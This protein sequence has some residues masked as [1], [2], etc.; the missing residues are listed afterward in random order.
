MSLVEKAAYLKGL[1]DGMELDT[2]KK[3]TRL[4]KSVIDLL[5]DMAASVEEL[6]DSTENIESEL[7][8]VAEE[9]LGI[10]HAL[11]CDCDSF[12]DEDDD[13]CG[14]GE[15]FYYQVACPTCGEE[16]TVDESILDLG[17]IQ[18]PNCG[19]ELEFDLESDGCC[20]CSHE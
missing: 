13:A 4:L 17:K 12:E 15:E 7:D 10:E 14:C 20:D 11:E 5:N 9:L 6:E 3:E 18:C 19:E 1:A 16:I 8:E 2:D